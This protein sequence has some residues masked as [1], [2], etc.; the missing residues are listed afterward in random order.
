MLNLNPSKI[1]AG[2][3]MNAGRF[4][5]LLALAALGTACGEAIDIN[6]VGP[7][8]VDKR[9]F[10]G[11][12]YARGVVVDKQFGT[13]DAFVGVE[14]SLDRIKWEI[15]ENALIGYRSYE[16]VPGADPSNPG[17]Q[18]IIAMFPIQRHFDIRRQYNPLNGVENNVIEENDYDRPWWERQYM[19]VDWSINAARTYDV[20]AQTFSGG[21]QTVRRNSNETPNYPWKVRIGDQLVGANVI[22]EGDYI[23]TTIDGLLSADPYVCYYLDGLSPCN[24]ANVK[25]KYSFLR[26]PQDNDYVPMDYPDVV[27]QTVGS[28]VLAQTGEA[29][30]TSTSDQLVA[31]GRNPV[32]R[33]CTVG[34]MDRDGTRLMKVKDEP[35]LGVR[36]CNTDPTFGDDPDTCREAL[37]R[38]DLDPTSDRVAITPN[39]NPACDPNHHSPDDCVELTTTVFSRFGY[40]RTDRFQVD[41]ENGTQYNARERLINRHNIWA[42]SIDDATGRPL[43]HDKRPVKPIIYYLNVGF[44][45]DLLEITQTRIAD[46]WNQAFMDAVAAARGLKGAHELPANLNEGFAGFPE[47]RRMF[48]I[49]QNSCNIPAARAYA[50]AHD[51][52][53][54]LAQ[55]NIAEIAYG[56]LEEACAVLEFESQRRR[57][58]GKDIK[59]F[60][61]EQLGDLRYNFLNWAAKAELAGPL[62]YGPSASDPI[63]GEII[64]ANANIYGASVD[65][66]ANWGADIVQLLNGDIE[67]G[68]IINGTV[69]REHVEAIRNRW[70]AGTPKERVDA[71]L[72]L[73]DR[74]AAR[75]SDSRYFQPIPVTALQQGLTKL[76]DSGLEEEFLIDSETLRLFGNDVRSFAAGQITEQMMENA[77]PSSWARE[78]IPQQML[79]AANARAIGDVSNQGFQASDVLGA[80]G[81]VEELTDYLG[82]KNFCFVA[83]QVEPAIADLA[84][85]IKAG[86]LSRDEIVKL[87]RANVYVGVTAHELGHT[88]GLR[89]NFEGSADALNYFPQYWGVGAEGLPEGKA[90]LLGLSG[91]TDKY[92][93]QYSSIMDYHQR[94]NSDWAGI[95]LYDKAAIKLGYAE[96]VEVFDEP[97]GENFVAR[98][99]IGR[100]FLLD[101]NDFPSLVSGRNANAAIDDLFDDA[102]AAALSGD[103]TALMDI[104]NSGDARLIARPENLY[105]RKD[106]PMRDWLRNEVLRSRFTGGFDDNDCASQGVRNQ[107]GCAD[108]VLSRFGLTDDDG[109]SPKIAVPYSYCSDE[110]AFGGNLTCNRWDMGATSREI[111]KNAG[112]MYEFYYPF[113]AFRRDRVLNPFGSWAN[114]YMNRL[115]SRT[116]QPMLNAYRFFYYY[117]RAQTLRVYPTIRDWGT[118]ALQGMDFFVRVLQQPEPGTY[119][120]VNDTWIPEREAS[121]ADCVAGNTAEIGLDQ[122]RIFESNWDNEYVFQPI[123]IGNY[124]DKALAIQAMTSS[125]AFFFRDFSQETNRGAFSIGYYR[126]FQ[127]E[128]LKL[129]GGLMRDDTSVY[130]PRLFD[131]D[132]DGRLEVFYQPFLTTGIYGEPLDNNGQTPGDPIRPSTSYQLRNWAAIFGMVNMTS[133][134]DQTL[135]FATRARITLKGQIGEPNVD[136]DPNGDG[137]DDIQIIEFTDPLTHLSYRS[138]AYDDPENA[139]G[140]RM[141]QDAK[142]FVEGEWQDA[143][144]ALTAAEQGGDQGAI[145]DARVAVQRAN[146]RLNEKLQVIDFVVYLGDIFEFPGG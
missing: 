84:A 110:F 61:W 55:N 16:K 122:G 125:N 27:P 132:G 134:L 60:T 13:Y 9:I 94:F 116:Y 57:A 51:M 77:R 14:G 105:R 10:T 66:Y 35:G 30:L 73:F 69:S 98:D 115:F 138:V 117:R 107:P 89:H 26:V 2:A 44:P 97:P 121:P 104:A 139:I 7:N 43:P 54:V 136:T 140:F 52:E 142:D 95:G 78:H 106:I 82:R 127:N 3:T 17:E 92:E 90:H 145:R 22:S 70:A 58:A 76:R 101:P 118:A 79:I 87:I 141:L 5:S 4:L 45:T 130:A 86:G 11:E 48:E 19:R 25:L 146:A 23:E 53:D 40:F 39:G 42:K 20:G 56:N 31:A 49:R 120:K 24:G 75:M 108:I 1:L 103:S 111:V 135:D 143:Q 67:T 46:D 133:T 8:V 6:R 96:T 99:W 83:S 63:T 102:Y 128:M 37:V 81:K 109:R 38:C 114:G 113:D 32:Q 28:L 34:E 41:R 64:S 144:D 100:T 18:N 68:D 124:W 29:V 71:F 91:L 15:T 21:V 80:A 36:M 59:V 47:V 88:F 74:R 129:F 93:V 126:I 12:W 119:C 65:T 137:V 85:R 72:T 50:A 112:E 33:L 123:N 131:E 62:G